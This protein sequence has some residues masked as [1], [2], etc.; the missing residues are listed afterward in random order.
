MPTAARHLAYLVAC[1]VR[2][3]QFHGAVTPA[4][5]R[6][7]F[8]Y[9]ALSH[10]RAGNLRLR[11]EIDTRRRLSTARLARL[12]AIVVTTILLEAADWITLVN[13]RAAS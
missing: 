13:A 8:P 12:I 1:L 11:N 10:Q 4:S 3:A 7:D 2:S 5:L 6:G 9:F